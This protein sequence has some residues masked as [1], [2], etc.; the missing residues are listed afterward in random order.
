[1]N[2]RRETRE[3]ERGRPNPE[4]KLENIEDRFRREGRGK[5]KVP[6]LIPER[7]G[8][9]FGGREDSKILDPLSLCSSV[10]HSHTPPF[11][12]Q[13]YSMLPE[14][15]ACVCAWFGT[16]NGSSSSLSSAPSSSSSSLIS[17]RHLH[18]LVRWSRE[19]LSLPPSRT[20]PIYTQWKLPPLFW[21]PTPKPSS[22]PAPTGPKRGKR[23]HRGRNALRFGG[24]TG[25]V[26]TCG[27]VVLR[28]YC[29]MVDVTAVLLLLVRSLLRYIFRA[30]H[31]T[32]GGGRGIIWR[33]RRHR[34]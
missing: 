12:W 16:S 18:W 9:F 3:K 26:S 4:T 31:V 20:L 27:R 28:C 15:A 19:S 7:G 10:V 11:A 14:R 5:E 23:R 21:R 25:L 24:E 32:A 34:K 17:Q 33:R 6:G 1:M 29:L 22:I 30:W 2:G 13:L 8:R